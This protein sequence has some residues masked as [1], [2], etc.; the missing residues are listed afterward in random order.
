MA[1]FVCDRFVS[2]D[3]VDRPETFD[4]VKQRPL[5]GAALEALASDGDA[6][7]QDMATTIH[8]VLERLGMADAAPRPP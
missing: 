3:A 5:E 4:R 2:L 7:E 6:P 8:T 1:V